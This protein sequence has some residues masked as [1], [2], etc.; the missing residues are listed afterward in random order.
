MPEIIFEINTETGRME[1]KIEGVQGPQCADVAAIVKDLAGP[2][3]HEENTRE[4]YTLLNIKPQVQNKR[5]P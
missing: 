2:P 1:M 3:E 4:F 5:T